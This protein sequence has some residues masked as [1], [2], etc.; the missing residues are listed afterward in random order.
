L[1]GAENGAGT[2]AASGGATNGAV[3]EREEWERGEGRPA[4]GGRPGAW[5]T[6]GGCR[7]RRLPGGCAGER[8]PLAAGNREQGANL[9]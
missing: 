5:E 8:R 1:V 4:A 9:D 7:G 3:G 6:G 2:A